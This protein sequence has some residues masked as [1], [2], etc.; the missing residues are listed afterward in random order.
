MNKTK[1]RAYTRKPKD[2]VPV[3]V[4]PKEV[5]M[6]TDANSLIALAMDKNLDADKMQRL[7]SMKHEEEDRAAKREFDIHFALMQAELPILV[8]TKQSHTNKYV[9]LDEMVIQCKPVTSKHGFAFYWDRED[10]D[11]K[12]A[13]ITFT[14]SGWG[15]AKSNYM[16]VFIDEPM[17]SREGKSVTNKNQMNGASDTYGH[18]YTMKAGLGLVESDEDT[19]GNYEDSTV[20]TGTMRKAEPVKNSASRQAIIDEIRR[21]MAPFT[22]TERDEVEA[23]IESMSTDGALIAFK[24]QCAKRRPRAELKIK[25]VI[26][27][28]VKFGGTNG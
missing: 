17:K 8:R 23:Q 16:I 10:L 22:P 1:K 25:P 12:R 24:N 7:I 6:P 26:K 3:K 15:W 28:G 14:V 11:E 5:S 13:K 18:R 19:D 27:E 20:T 4:E 2:L 9:P 21:I